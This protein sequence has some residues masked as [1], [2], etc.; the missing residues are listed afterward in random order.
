MTKNHN[1][2]KE[3][4]NVEVNDYGNNDPNY[5]NVFWYGGEVASIKTTKGIYRIVAR[6][7]VSCDLIA[8]KDFIDENGNQI[9]KDDIIASV[10]DKNEDGLFKKEMSP[11]IK[12][13][14]ELLD[15]LLFEHDKYELYIDN[16]NWFDLEFYNN[17]GEL[18]YDDYILSSDTLKEAISEVKEEI[19]E[20]NKE[21]KKTALYLRFD[22]LKTD[23]NLTINSKIEMLLNI[24][25]TVDC[26]K[27][28]VIKIY[29]DCCSGIE[30]KKH[31]LSSLLNDIKL[32]QIENVFTP[33][34]STLSRDT[35]W[36]I[37]AQKEIAKT[38]TNI[39]FAK[40]GVTLKEVI[41]PTILLDIFRDVIPDDYEEDY[42]EEMDEIDYE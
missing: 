26:K 35:K 27:T 33:S 20:E 30:N 6:G 23:L 31:A 2:I 24:M 5:D 37:E 21:S 29:I 22:G 7:I 12:N 36:L 32:L 11:F 38:D 4:V 8:K 39:Y 15:I 28:D 40:D 3:I 34:L 42:E 25:N 41:E 16:N 14:E 9:K 13:D 1:Y 19:L 18:E 17:S 10:K